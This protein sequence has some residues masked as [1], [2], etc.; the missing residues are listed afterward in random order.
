MS[1]LADFS[2]APEVGKQDSEKDGPLLSSS[3]SDVGG[4]QG[5][6]TDSGHEEE[7]E[8]ETT[9]AIFSDFDCLSVAGGLEE[10]E[11]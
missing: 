2:L 4:E 6:A 10:V 7:A 9:E 3:R 8:S 11:K 1:A 5:E